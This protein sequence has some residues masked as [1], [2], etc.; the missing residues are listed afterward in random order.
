[1]KSILE[2]SRRKRFVL[3]DRTLPSHDL[4][5][6]GGGNAGRRASGGEYLWTSPTGIGSLQGGMLTSS[7]FRGQR[8]YQGSDRPTPS[9]ASCHL[10]QV[11]GSL[12]VSKLAMPWLAIHISPTR[13]YLATTQAVHTQSRMVISYT[14]PIR[15]APE[16]AM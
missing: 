9:K 5:S 16:P 3:Q 8:G 14:I 4:E 10:R 1:M 7:R 12:L 11:E 2:L 13:V 6:I 15:K